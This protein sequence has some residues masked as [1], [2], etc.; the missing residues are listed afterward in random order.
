M[1]FT[2]RLGD[3]HRPLS[4]ECFDKRVERPDVERGTG[5]V[6]KYEPTI[7]IADLH[8]SKVNAGI[9]ACVAG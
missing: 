8:D 5:L 9:G 6:L 3:R 2:D 7:L 4:L 1:R